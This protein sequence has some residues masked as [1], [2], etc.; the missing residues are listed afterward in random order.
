M[1]RIGRRIVDAM[2]AIV[3]QVVVR[4]ILT[5]HRP[6]QM[7]D[8]RERGTEARPPQ[9]SNPKRPTEREGAHRELPPNS[10][11]VRVCCGP[12]STAIRAAADR[13]WAAQDAPPQQSARP[14][15]KKRGNAGM[16]KHTAE[17]TAS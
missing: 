14:G 17:A 6:V 1:N 16:A 12:D 10:Y 11:S 3:V 5:W 2:L 4:Q 9:G 7:D 8:S 15:R 13:P